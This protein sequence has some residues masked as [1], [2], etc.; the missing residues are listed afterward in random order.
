MSN[1]D[2]QIIQHIRCILPSGRCFFKSV[3]AN[4][5]P[6]IMSFEPAALHLQGITNRP[7]S[8]MIVRGIG[9]HILYVDDFTHIIHESNTERDLSLNHP[10]AVTM[11]L[12][13]DEKH[14]PIDGQGP[15][16]HKTDVSHLRGRG[17]F[18]RH[19]MS[20]RAELEQI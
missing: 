11:S 17:N 1:P 10:H 18:Y 4:P 13:K 2:G 16:V 19:A 20:A 8:T 5:N 14:A 6:N 12:G 9:L 7:V 15:P 3:D